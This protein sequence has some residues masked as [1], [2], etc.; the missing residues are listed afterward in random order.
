MKIR[1]YSTPVAALDTYTWVRF[2][3]QRD[4]TVAYTD[5]DGKSVLSIGVE[6]KTPMTRR[7][8][9][10]LV[11]MMV[12]EAKTRKLKK[13]AL[14]L[15]VCT[16]LPELSLEPHDMLH[17]VAENAHLANYEY[18]TYK[19]KPPRGWDTLDTLAVVGSL[20][21]A[22]KK[23]LRRGTV[24]AEEV[25]ACRDLSN[26][27]GGDMTPRVLARSI[28][29]S[30][31]GTGATVRVLKE[32]DIKAL[33][34]GALL[35][36][37][38]GSKEPPVFIVVEYH[39]TKK[40]NAPIVLAGKGVTYDTGGLSLKPMP[41]MLDMHH[42]MAGGAA[43]A[44]AVLAVARLRLPIHVVALI[45]T[46]ENA[47]GGESYRPGD[48][49]RSM[50]GKT[51]D[52]LDT[53]AEGRLLLADALTYAQRYKPS[54]VLDVATL[55]GAALGA[56]GTKASAVMSKDDTLAHELCMC[57][58]ESGDYLWP[59]PLWE[60]YKE[61][62]E[63]RFGDVSNVPKGATR[64]GGAIGA[65][66]FLAEFAEGYPWAHVDMA[67]RM[68]SDKSDGLA[69]GATGEPVRMLVRLLERRAQQT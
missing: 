9:A 7:R 34:M 62:V 2:D 67:P 10:A 1:T 33:G 11:R 53:D 23:A 50:S 24:I 25:N 6:K 63:G 15:E 40:K 45:P 29:T 35:G 42:D 47:V 64:Y 19:T 37:A 65:G 18:L 4:H 52:V 39:G 20:D 28:Q 16:T 54:L 36:V 30:A 8:F 46:A 22:M 26:T 57:G 17:M 32:K 21:A 48:I 56:L 69:P 49:L 66:M 13:V 51:I 58:E 61:M 59:L 12:Q 68:V 43:V 55:T 3:T 41:Y 14:T 31:R 27:P 38:R 44:H 5:Q 60:E